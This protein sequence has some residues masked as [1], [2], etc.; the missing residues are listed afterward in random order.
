MKFKPVKNVKEDLQE[1]GVKTN[2][3]MLL[4]VMSNMQHDVNLGI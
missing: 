3:N 1:S 4:D 2:H